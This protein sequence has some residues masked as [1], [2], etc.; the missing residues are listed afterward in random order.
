[1]Q[2][3]VR[4]YF[5]NSLWLLGEQAFRMLAGFAVGVYVARYL[6]ASQYGS[7]SYAFAFVA[8]F[9]ALARLGLDSVVVRRLVTEPSRREA[10]LGTAFWLRVGAAL[11]ALAAVAAAVG[12]TSAS[13]SE[14]LYVLIVACGL[15]V[16]AFDVLDLDL[17]A[18]ALS[19][20][21]ALCRAWQTVVSSV[22]KVALVIAQAELIAFAAVALLDQLALV[23]ALMLS[24][25]RA[26]GLAFIRRFD[27]KVVPELLRA[28][29]PLLASGLM[30]GVYARIDQVLVME[31]LGARAVGLYAV[32]VGLTEALYTVPLAVATAFFPALLA[33]RD[34]G[35][36]YQARWSML[37]RGLLAF[38]VAA[39]LA[40]SLASGAIVRLF[41]GAGF[42][43]A[44]PLLA[45]QSW[46]LVLICYSAVFGKWLL[47]EGLQ[48]L[49]PRMTFVALATNVAAILLL[50]PALG[51]IG[52]AYATLLTQLVPWLLF[53]SID[54]RLRAHL[55]RALLPAG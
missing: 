27:P 34:Q 8:M 13:A 51:L 2:R 14:R 18:R 23:L 37:Y 10:V 30:I 31:M 1:M 15:M 26:G 49:L 21:S 17:Q 48:G 3:G 16:Q 38:G 5:L 47:A 24:R 9:S 53:F 52:V 44:G 43:E 40:L 7:L 19:R 39:A 41:Y 50:A 33:V 20:T 46:T 45:V 54:A 29:A 25:R 36:L 12:A 6:G 4:R 55:R 35:R 42:A 22:A 28:A 11:L 32:A